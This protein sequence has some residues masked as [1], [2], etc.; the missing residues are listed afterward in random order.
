MHYTANYSES[1]SVAFVHTVI[2][3]LPI[4]KTDIDKILYDCRIPS[5]LLKEPNSRVSLHQY[6]K[7][8]SILMNASSDE[9][10][11][12]AKE[13][14]PLG[15]LSLLSHWLV[16]ATSI[17]DALKRFARFFQIL[18]K[19]LKVHPHFEE[20]KVHIVIDDTHDLENTFMAEFSSFI[21]HRMLCWLRKEIIKIDH[22]SFPFHQPSYAKD[23]RLMFYG[24]PISFNSDTTTISFSRS[25]LQR[26]LHPNPANLA[27]FLK[28]PYSELLVLNV[29]ADT[30]SSKVA[31]VIRDRLGNLPTLP[32][33]AKS[34]KIKPH[35]LHRKLANEG[36]TFQAI[37][38][39]IKRDVAIELL[40]NT[41][42]TIEEISEKLGFSETSP[43]TRTFKEWTGIPPSAYRKYN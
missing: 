18:G 2:S 8:M 19:G 36:I 33:L 3:K 27:Q 14:L 9:L 40:V 30:W 20:E 35:T 24:A 23:Y 12:H 7:L 37:K 6:A 22:I 13:P 5:H 38:N 16:L 43:F 39:Q 29:N 26:P 1:I 4:K 32:E 10:L 42:F 41:E 11:G 15:S 21:I 31:N 34:M 25:L 17:E 28:D